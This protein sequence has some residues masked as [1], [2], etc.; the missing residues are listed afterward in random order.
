M[1]P[2]AIR[3]ITQCG[4]LQGFKA[5]VSREPTNIVVKVPTHQSS[6][7][8]SSKAQ[9]GDGK[10]LGIQYNG[11]PV[12]RQHIPQQVLGAAAQGHQPTQQYV[13]VAYF[14]A[15]KQSRFRN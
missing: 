4:Y 1:I 15:F 3:A 2:T 11:A 8:D 14:D 12:P 7:D 5:H 9:H 13:Q 10:Q 6:A